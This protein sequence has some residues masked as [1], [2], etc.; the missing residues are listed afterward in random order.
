M[1]CHCMIV[2]AP[3]QLWYYTSDVNTRKH[4]GV[5]LVIDLSMTQ[6]S[7]QEVACAILFYT[8]LRTIIPLAA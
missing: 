6:A 8:S 3:S 4:A 5:L 1:P 7:H 2:T